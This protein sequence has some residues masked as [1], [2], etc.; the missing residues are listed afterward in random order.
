[1]HTPHP[2]ESSRHS[3]PRPRRAALAAL[4]LV[5]VLGAC[6]S[7]GDDRPV[8]APEVAAPALP[9]VGPPGTMLDAAG[10]YAVLAVV[11]AATVEVDRGAAGGRNV[12]GLVGI[13]APAPGQPA[14]CFAAEA[15]EEA[16]RL[17]AGQAVR[18]V[19]DP[20]L[21]QHDGE[22]RLSAYVW[23]DSGRMANHLLVEGGF[24][25][26]SAGTPDYLYREMFATAEE[27]AR[28]DGRGL[29]AA[30][31]CAGNIARGQR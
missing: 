1:M 29:W 22:G 21:A 9:V 25:R 11:D 3:R 30:H 12:V 24:V 18:L 27:R 4:G 28:Q 23:L 26:E 7:G 19:A 10:P 13:T 2:A 17:L 14:R 15:R 20:G 31:T 5:V 8:R 16:D 6:S